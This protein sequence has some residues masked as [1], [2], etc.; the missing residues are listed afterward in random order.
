[1]EKQMDGS[2]ANKQVKSI[3]KELQFAVALS[4]GDTSGVRE[5]ISQGIPS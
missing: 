1:M 4:H 2:I 5:F 3:S